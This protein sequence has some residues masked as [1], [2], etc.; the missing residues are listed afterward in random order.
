MLN[1]SMAEINFTDGNIPADILLD[2]LEWHL[3]AGADEVLASSPV[4]HLRPKEKTSDPAA[5]EKNR[6]EAPSGQP[7]AAPAMLGSSEASAQARHLARS[8]STLEELQETIRNFEGL[9]IRKTATNLVF[10][11]GHPGARIMLVGEAPGADEDRLGE[12]FVGVSGQLL[13]RMFEAIGLSRKGTDPCNSLYISNILNWRP[14]GNRTPAPGEIETSLPFIERHIELVSP[15][16][17]V[18]VGGVSAK[19][20]LG[21]NEGITRLRKIWHSYKV[22]GESIPALA[23]FHPSYLLRSPSQKR[24]AWDDL[25]LL[26]RKRMEMNLIR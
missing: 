13:D 14:P 11:T 1:N 8:A 23:T 22:K 3:H 4:D 7:P 9:A 25:L 12:P 17:L 6:A 24:A 10:G 2:A 15:D 5:P 21:R 19:A 18:F 26:Q 20:L 16:I